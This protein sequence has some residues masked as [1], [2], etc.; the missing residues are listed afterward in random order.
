[1]YFM[2]VTT[3]YCCERLPFILTTSG[4]TKTEAINW[5]LIFR[6]CAHI[7]SG[8][9]PLMRNQITTGY[10][11][12]WYYAFKACFYKLLM[13]EITT[14]LSHKWY[15]KR[16]KPQIDNW[17]QNVLHILV[18]EIIM[19]IVNKVTTGYCRGY[20]LFLLQVV[21]H[22]QKPQIDGSFLNVLYI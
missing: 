19:F 9:I 7:R 14:Y 2:L 17:F 13:P 22:E 6:S 20:H 16:W 11:C 12:E 5:R 18:Q 1:M 10:F 21:C 15:T 4:M 8:K 3:C